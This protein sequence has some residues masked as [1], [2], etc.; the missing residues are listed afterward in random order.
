MQTYQIYENNCEEFTF[1]NIFNIQNTENTNQECSHISIEEF[2]NKIRQI[3]LEN[4]KDDITCSS[5]TIIEK[6]TYFI[7][8]LQNT[9]YILMNEIK[10]K[11][12][13]FLNRTYFVNIDAKKASKTI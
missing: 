10:E 5:F 2:Q 6:D 9:E 8:I 13:D 11:L 1:E 7:F 12:M 4:E 3:S